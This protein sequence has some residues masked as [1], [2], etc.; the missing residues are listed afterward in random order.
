MKKVI[1]CLFFLY[2]L[3][4][5][6][7]LFGGRTADPSMNSWKYIL[8]YSNVCPFATVGRYISFFLRHGDCE[9]FCLAMVNIGGNFILFMPM[10][11]FLPVLFPFLRHFRQAFF[12]ILLLVLLSEFFQGF[13]RIGI[14]DIDD[15]LVNMSGA[16]VGILVGR[17]FSETCHRKPF[18]RI[19]FD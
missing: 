9:S 11:I 13:F 15:L 8:S 19:H 17:N 12:V 3:I 2:C 6:E 7:I 4:L 1:L 14:P 10:G 16:C 18:V 5:A